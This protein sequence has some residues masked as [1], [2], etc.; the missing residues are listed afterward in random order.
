MYDDART[1]K[2]NVADFMLK[3]QNCCVWT[4]H[5]IVLIIFILY[6][7]IFIIVIIFE[8]SSTIQIHTVLTAVLIWVVM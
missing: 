7:S 6:F 1:Y 8:I 2:L 4:G 5:I 3:K